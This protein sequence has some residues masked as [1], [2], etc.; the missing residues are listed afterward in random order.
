MPSLKS[1]HIT[2]GE[3]PNTEPTERSNSPAV[4]SSVMASAIM[5]SSGVKAS[6]LPMLSIDRNVAFSSGE[7]DDGADEQDERPDLRLGEEAA[8]TGP[9]ACPRS[10]AA[11]RWS[12]LV[13]LMSGT[14][15]AAMCPTALGAWLARE[16]GTEVPASCR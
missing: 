6:R 10:M 9:R 8:E 5:P 4:I 14:H 3:K 12:L 15:R 7:R 16:A 2:T 11:W 13:R 1:V